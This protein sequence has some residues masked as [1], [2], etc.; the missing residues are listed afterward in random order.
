MDRAATRAICRERRVRS[1]CQSGGDGS[2]SNSW[3]GALDSPPSKP[4]A[5][6]IAPSDAPSLAEIASS[7]IACES[8]LEPPTA[9]W[10]PAWSS[11]DG[12]LPNGSLGG[13]ICTIEWH[14]GQVAIVPTIAGSVTRSWLPQVRHCTTKGWKDKR[15]SWVEDSAARADATSIGHHRTGSELTLYHASF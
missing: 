15:V 12:S 2:L 8:M 7:V 4:L 13:S 3:G 6:S 11:P 14:L 1:L 10:R 5:V 9:T